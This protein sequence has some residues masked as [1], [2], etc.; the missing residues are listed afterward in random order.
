M[1]ERE[2]DMDIERVVNAHCSG[3]TVNVYVQHHKNRRKQI[4]SRF[5]SCFAGAAVCLALYFT[6][7]L[8][9][10]VSI[11][12]FTVFACICSG[13]VGRFAEMHRTK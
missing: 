1:N 13:C 6:G 9:G 10:W 3:D 2:M 12:A 11:P 7:L 4:A 8:V 5:F